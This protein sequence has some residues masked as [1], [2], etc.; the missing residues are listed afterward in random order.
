[1]NNNPFDNYRGTSDYAVRNNL[2]ELPMN[3][4]KFLI[5]IALWLNAAANI[6]MGVLY[7][8]GGEQTEEMLAAFPILKTVDLVYGVLTLGLAVFALYTRFALAGYKRNAPKLIVGM[9]TYGLATSL[10]YNIAILMITGSAYDQV[11]LI[12]TVMSVIVSAALSAAMVG[13][14]YVYFKKRKGLFNK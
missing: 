11:T 12:I 5:W 3:W 6:M 1:M 4:Y 7:I 9:Y 10:V 13:C 2:R 14:N 8:R